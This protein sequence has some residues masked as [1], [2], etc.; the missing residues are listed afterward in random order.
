MN[1]NRLDEMEKQVDGALA[2][3]ADEHKK[4]T[5]KVS[6]THTGLTDSVKHLDKKVTKLHDR[7]TGLTDE[8]G[9]IMDYLTLPWWRRLVTRRPR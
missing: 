9:E 7:I 3:M 5:F 1:R 6:A 2:V 8:Y 4:L